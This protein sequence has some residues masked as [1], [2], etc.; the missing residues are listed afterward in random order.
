MPGHLGLLP[1][2]FQLL[3]LTTL[4]FPVPPLHKEPCQENDYSTDDDRLK[5]LKPEHILHRL[6]L[7]E[8]IAG[9]AQHCAILIIHIQNEAIAPRL[10]VRIDDA[11]ELTLP[12]LRP[13]CIEALKPVLYEGILGRKVDDLRENLKLLCRPCDGIRTILT[14]QHLLTIRL[15]RINLH[16]VILPPA[17]VIRKL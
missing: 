12:Q 17:H 6:L 9:F 1:G 10:Q 8:A 13:A 14:R 2:D 16:P 15:G 11:R 4:R 5:Q 7:F 3:F